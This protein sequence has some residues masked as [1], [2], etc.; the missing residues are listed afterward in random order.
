MW[1]RMTGNACATAKVRV[2]S[3]TDQPYAREAT[4]LDTGG[5]WIR[6]YQQMQPSG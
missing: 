2:P 1:E 3:P 4:Y 5:N 6:R